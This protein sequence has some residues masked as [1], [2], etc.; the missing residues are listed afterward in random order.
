MVEVVH[1]R[2][3]RGGVRRQLLIGYAL[4]VWAGDIVVVGEGFKN[5]ASWSIG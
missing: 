2:P 3:I 5:G 1:L 4:R